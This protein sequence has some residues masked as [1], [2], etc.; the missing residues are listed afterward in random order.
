MLIGREKEVA[1]VTG[2]SS[3]FGAGTAAR[4]V[5]MGFRVFGTSRNGTGGATGV[6]MLPL[7]VDS[8]D[9]VRSCIAELLK[10]AGR[11]DAS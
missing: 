5:A 11:L 10:C 6:E 3:G 1:L 4:L 7:D 2:A 8:E 9:S